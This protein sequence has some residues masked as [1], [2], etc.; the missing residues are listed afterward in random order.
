M[1]EFTEPILVAVLRV[2]M[3]IGVAFLLAL[4]F[5][6]LYLR[7]KGSRRRRRQQGRYSHSGPGASGRRPGAPRS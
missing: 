6:P 4:R 5:R 3:F 7:Y 1:F 2:A